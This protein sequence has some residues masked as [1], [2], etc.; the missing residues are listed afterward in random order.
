MNQILGG[1]KM[2]GLVLAV[3]V[4]C[5]SWTAWSQVKIDPSLAGFV[6]GETGHAY[7]KVL[8]L[9]EYIPMEATPTIYNRQEVVDYLKYQSRGAWSYI[10]NHL[11]DN[12]PTVNNHLQPLYLFWLNQS[13]SAN[14]TPEGIQILARTPGIKKIY[15]DHSIEY[16]DPIAGRWA[17]PNFPGLENDLPYN[18]K[19]I[20]LD[21]LMAELPEV[22]GQGVLMGSID[23]GV[24]ATHPDL[25][26]KVPLF[27]DS[28]NGQ[29]TEPFDMQFHGTHTIGTMIGT[30]ETG[31][32]IAPNAQL[33]AAGGL[34]WEG[35]VR[36]ME[37]MLNPDGNDQTM[38]DMPRV[39]NNSWNSRAAPDQEFHYRAISAWEA[40][41]ILPVFS[42]GNSGRSGPRSITPPKEHPATLAVGNLQQDGTINESS[43]IG[44]AVFEGNDI[45]KP[46]ISAPGTDIKST[47][48]GNQYGELTGTSMAA[49]HVSAVAA[50]VFQVAPNLT[51]A[52]VK[53]LLI[54]TVTPHNQIGALDGVG[55]WNP[56]YGYGKL[57]AYNAVRSA[58]EMARSGNLTMSFNAVLPRQMQIGPRLSSQEVL[59]MATPRLHQVL[60][61]P[62]RFE[63]RTWLTLDQI[64]S[65]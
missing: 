28:Q 3:L 26:G 19:A 8:V 43:S 50:L 52:D 6:R 60:N 49:P 4:Y 15:A 34:Q 48:P 63:G 64:Y 40:A 41:G 10:N 39:V 37:W 32:G 29:V 65:M 31:I 16:Q 51:P 36:A 46:E 12:E 45:Q 55:N 38:N 7:V 1:N 21:R 44:P 61:M 5:F 56:K 62:K 27:F 30:R 42:A 17:Q 22:N 14:S 13:F 23:T 47:M 25:Q 20:G 53:S 57:N 11:G 59:E 54:R 2:K 24:D 9:M 35:Q 33:I 18:F 58:L